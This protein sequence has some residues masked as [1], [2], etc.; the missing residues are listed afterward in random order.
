MNYETVLNQLQNNELSIEDAY[1]KLYKERKT[2]PGKRA[3]FVKM[4][5]TVP[6]E[7]KGINTF[8]RILFMLPI[9]IVFA[10]IGLGFASRFVKDATDEI[11]FKEISRLLKYSRNTKIQVDAKDAKIDIKI[12]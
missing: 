6:N 5:I 12:M 3:F 8:L 4:N 2:K 1:E 9:P 11:D 10:R 7:G